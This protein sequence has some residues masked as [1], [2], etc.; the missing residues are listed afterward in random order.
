MNTMKYLLKYL[1][2]AFMVV[3]IASFSSIAKCE[4]PH[5]E[6]EHHGDE[7]HGGD[8]EL[9]VVNGQIVTNKRVYA[10]ELG[11]I[12]PNEV[13]EPGFDNSTGT[14]SA[15]SKIGFSI[16]DSL[17]QWDG[18]DFENIA[19]ETMSVHFGTSL[20]PAVTPEQPSV[21]SGFEL[22]VSEEGEWHRHYDFVLNDPADPGIYLL[23]L[24]LSSDDP[25]V[26]QTEP[27]VIVFNQNESEL[28]HD[29]AIEF[30]ELQFNQNIPEPSALLLL[31]LGLALLSTRV[32]RKRG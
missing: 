7:H 18:H 26:Q 31:S 29:A 28:N 27:F 32:G 25:E 2:T 4:D 12:S 10:A 11:E 9:Q 23:Q 14:F 6:G 21:V 1:A 22:P 5:H 3:S 30:A 16:L 24:Q 15:G 20:G 19:N 13:D 8:I 17:R